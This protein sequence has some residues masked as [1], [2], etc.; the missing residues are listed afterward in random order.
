MMAC[1]QRADL[2]GEGL[3]DRGGE[4]LRKEI[5]SRISTGPGFTT[6]FRLTSGAHDSVGFYS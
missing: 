5:P 2:G 4:F 1:G 6:A 3:F